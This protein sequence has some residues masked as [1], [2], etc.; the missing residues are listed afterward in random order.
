MSICPY[1]RGPGDLP[2]DTTESDNYICWDGSTEPTFSTIP[3]IRAEY[4]QLMEVPND[5]IDTTHVGEIKYYGRDIKK[6]RWRK[7]IRRFTR[8]IRMLLL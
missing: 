8:A 3:N 5:V 4:E 2:I 7:F 6:R 1:P